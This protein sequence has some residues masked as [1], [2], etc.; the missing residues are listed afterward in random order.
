MIN[1]KELKWKRG[2][3][4]AHN[5]TWKAKYNDE[6]YFNLDY[7]FLK[8]NKRPIWIRLYKGDNCMDS[9]LSNNIEECID[10]I[11]NSESKMEDYKEEDVIMETN[12]QQYHEFFA[13]RPRPYYDSGQS[14]YERL[15]NIKRD[16]ERI[17]KHAQKYLD[18]LSIKENEVKKN[19]DNTPKVANME[20]SVPVESQFDVTVTVTNPFV[21]MPVELNI[22]RPHLS[23]EEAERVISVLQESVNF[24]KNFESHI[25]TKIFS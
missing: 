19:M 21:P 24:M 13:P 14:T 18:R 3:S 17:I 8:V 4:T 5:M 6:F 1:T 16:R 7:S 9:M 11:K 20:Y 12:R 15:M 23:I 2:Y 25:E 22:S 10:W